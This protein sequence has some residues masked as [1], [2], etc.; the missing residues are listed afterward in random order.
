VGARGE[1]RE[2]LLEVFLAAGRAHERVR[3]GGAADQFLELGP[4]I[5]TKVFEDRHGVKSP[6]SNIISNNP[7]NAGPATAAVLQFPRAVAVDTA[8][9]LYIADGLANGIR[10]VTVGII[11]AF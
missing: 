10:K 7:T 8:G 1:S 4:A 5:G 9:N 11:N 6:Y 3:V 2:F